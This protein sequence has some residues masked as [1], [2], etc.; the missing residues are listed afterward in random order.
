V[1]LLVPKICIQKLAAQAQAEARRNF[2]AFR[3]YMRPGMLWGWWAE[4][5]AVELQHFYLDLV[6]GKRPQLALMA[7][8]QH[9]KSWAATDFIAWVAGKNPN[10]KTSPATA[11]TWA[12]APTSTYSACSCRRRIAARSLTHAWACMAGSATRR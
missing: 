6:A 4:R 7:P 11:T 8:P 12:C 2:W 1:N 10:L 5:V 3:R 9:G